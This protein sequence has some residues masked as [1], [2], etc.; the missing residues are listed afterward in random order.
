MY[1]NNMD[2]EVINGY[3]KFWVQEHHLYLLGKKASRKVM[4]I[5]QWI[6]KKLKLMLNLEF[7][8]KMKIPMK[9]IYFLISK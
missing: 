6:M 8:K 3:M 4:L 2:M 7:L 5:T 9:K 1:L